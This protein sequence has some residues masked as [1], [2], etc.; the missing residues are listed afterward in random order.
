VD[1]RLGEPEPVIRVSL[2]LGKLVTGE[3]PGHDRIATNDAPQ[4]NQRFSQIATA[5]AYETGRSTAFIGSLLVVFVWVATGPFF[6]L[7][8]HMAARY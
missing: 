2:A 7:F 1:L 6:S 5:V 4:M 8:R 3:L